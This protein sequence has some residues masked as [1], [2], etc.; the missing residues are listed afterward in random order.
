MVELDGQRARGRRAAGHRRTGGHHERA[1]SPST[2][3]E[4]I[5]TTREPVTL[6]D[7]GAHSSRRTGMVANLKERHVQLESDVHGIVP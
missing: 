5:L 4:Q 3:N 7:D 1:A 2:R 6:D